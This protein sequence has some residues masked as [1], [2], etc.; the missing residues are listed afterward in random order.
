MKLMVFSNIHLQESIQA[1]NPWKRKKEIFCILH[2]PAISLIFLNSPSFSSSNLSSWLIAYIICTAIFTTDKIELVNWFQDTGSWRVEKN[3]IGN[4]ELICFVRPYVFT[5]VLASS[6]S[7]PLAHHTL[8][9]F[10]FLNISKPELV[11]LAS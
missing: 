10:I 11:T 9:N 1:L 6:D 8:Q 7:F 4:K 3:S 5:L 2:F